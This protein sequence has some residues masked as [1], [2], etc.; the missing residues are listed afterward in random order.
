MLEGGGE[1]SPDHVEGET[2]TNMA[3]IG[4]AQGYTDDW[5]RKQDHQRL[6]YHPRL[7]DYQ[8]PYFQLNFP[9]GH[10]ITGDHRIP[11]DH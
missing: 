6:R 2:T 5:K 3:I 8:S 10:R 1:G 9:L 4:I 11:L 7:L